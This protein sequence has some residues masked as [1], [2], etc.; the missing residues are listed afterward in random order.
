MVAEHLAVDEDQLWPASSFTD[1]LGADSLDLVELAIAVETEFGIIIPEATL[2]HLRTYTDLTEATVALACREAGGDSREGPPLV[3]TRLVPSDGRDGGVLERAEWLTPYMA[4]E[5]DADRA[6]AGRRARLEVTVDDGSASLAML[7]GADGPVIL[8]HDPR[9][10]A[11]IPS[12]GRGAIA[13]VRHGPLRAE[14]HPLNGRPSGE[15]ETVARLS[16]MQGQLVGV[17]ARVQELSSQLGH[18][19][20]ALDRQRTLRSAMADAL[21]DLQRTSK[22]HQRAAVSAYSVP[23]GSGGV[24]SGA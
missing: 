10:E 14:R 8:A 23:T 24:F 13:G 5:I 6:W 9:P 2:E 20:S 3:R 16:E 17:E 4:E 11:E 1:D 21:A 7:D 22:S 12:N 18:L 15:T 19:R